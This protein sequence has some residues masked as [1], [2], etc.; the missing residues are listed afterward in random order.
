M[1]IALA[2]LVQI[3][4]IIVSIKKRHQYQDL[5]G[6]PWNG[7]TLEWS[8]PSPAPVYNFAIIP[9]VLSRDAFWEMKKENKI[10]NLKYEDIKMPKNTPMGIYLAGFIFLFGF[11]LVW[12][13]F[14]LTAVSLIGAVVIF[15]IRSMDEETEYIIPAKEVER[16]DKENSYGKTN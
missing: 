15:I 3:L 6:D 8:V 5:S 7:R 2:I 1:I 9:T 11:S 4:Q 16:M 10:T 14:W 12:H 13:I